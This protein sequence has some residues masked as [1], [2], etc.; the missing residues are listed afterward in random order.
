MERGMGRTWV[1]KIRLA[2]LRT[3]IKDATTIRGDV[4]EVLLY[5]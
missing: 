3:L 4:Q 1:E 5:N 2:R